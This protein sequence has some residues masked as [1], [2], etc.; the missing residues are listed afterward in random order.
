MS[1]LS[2]FPPV[3]T[4][5]PNDR[6]VFTARSIPPPGMWIG[7]ANSADIQSDFSLRIDAAESVMSAA[8]GHALFS[9]IGIIEFIIDDQFRPT[10]TNFFFISAFINDV[11]GFQYAYSV[12][13]A[14]TT[15]KVF[16]EVGSEIFTESYSTVSGDTYRVELNAGFRLYRKN[17]GATEFVLK[18]SRVGL[19]TVVTY[20][21]SYQCGI[22]EP[23]AT[24]PAR[25]PAPRLIGDWQ[26]W[27][28]II[29]TSPSHGALSNTAGKTTEYSSG[30][31]PG[32]Y[33]LA[34]AM[35]A[36]ADAGNVQRATATINIPA[37]RVLG[38]T[39]VTMLPGS[40]A[41][42]KTNYDA[43]Q[44]PLITWSVISGGGSFTQDE[45][46]AP[47][48]A[49]TTVVRAFADVNDQVADIT[50]TV[51]ALITNASGFTAAKISEQIDFDHN[52]SLFPVF[53]GAGGAASGTG[54]ITPGVPRDV[55][56]NE[57]L[58]LN[59]IILLFD[60][61]ANEAVSTPSGY[62]VV[63][64]SPQ[65]TGTAG[66]T[67]STRLDAFWKRAT[68]TEAAPTITDPGDHAIGRI[69]AFRGC[70]GSGNPWDVTS[71]DT[72]ASSTSVSI[73]GDTTTVVNTL[74]VA[75]VANA[76]DTL[77]AQTSAYVNTDLANLTER[78]DNNT[79]Q[80]N[81]GGF[82]VVTGEKATAGSYAATTATL[83]TASV[84]GRMSI[85]LKPALITWTASIGSINSTSGVWTAPSLAGQVAK[86]TATNG[87]LS[88][89][90]EVPVLEVFPIEP[91]APIKWDRR[92]TVLVSR[93]EDR[94]R[95]SRVKDKDGKAFE[96]WEITLN[97]I[98]IADVGTL[99]NFWDAHY[100][101]KKFIFEDKLNTPT[102]RKVVYFD[103]DITFEAESSCAVRASFRILEA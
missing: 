85:A 27:V 28:A 98:E 56:L 50:I 47:A 61:T 26:L 14:A 86:I 44:S 52:I 65:G 29:W 35:E 90:I 100:P 83:A 73:P 10:S 102:L 57:I 24:D 38:A 1:R 48:T 93:A 21:M 5:Y 30:V 97:N 80:G 12:R 25:I 68:A 46:T 74:V 55:Q 16:D 58:Q 99:R 4:V 62:A 37:L 76:T 42:F 13:I 64:D 92:K 71:G 53:L 32:E 95:T 49:G 69:L 84:Q 11:A 23:V 88:V 82:A 3:A 8:G 2:I 54:N 72:G 9:G 63:A 66:G 96:A 31:T 77:T 94:S 70:I 39:S 89:T 20:P 36:A 75:A 45:F 51:P 81:G 60:E 40:K 18:H 17:A 91:S 41:R 101:G 34:V 103:S 6:Q 15:V 43:A 33:T 7:V 87:T 22:T 78:V 59:D 79:D 67:T 19:A